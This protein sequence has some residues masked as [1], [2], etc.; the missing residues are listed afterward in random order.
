MRIICP[1]C[2]AQYEVPDD[3][4]PP[5][6][7]DVQCS[8]CGQTWYQEHPDSVLEVEA[9]KTMAEDEAENPVGGNARAKRETPATEDED[10]LVVRKSPPFDPVPAPKA[11][12]SD[13]PEGRKP[14]D[15]SVA[16]V[17]REEAEIEARARRKALSGGLESQPD[18]GLNDPE[19]SERPRDAQDRMARMRGEEPEID[20]P[21]PAKLREAL[22]ASRRDL[23]PDIEEINSTLRSNSDRS[24]LT[25]PGQT[26]QIEAQEA[27]SSRRGFTLTL[28]LVALLVVTYVFAPQIAQAL[29]SVDPWLSAYVGIID[30]WRMWL[31]NQVASLLAWLDAAAVSS[32]K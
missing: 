23:L 25:D 22:P 2:D 7:R 28:L 9:H 27:R 5:D 21:D 29:P 19:V 15:P 12:G 8:N 31:D 10:D 20:A 30:G 11:P 32:S 24:P 26:A 6:G 13:R 3:V 17:L 1:N 4:M 16:D 18:L 14:L